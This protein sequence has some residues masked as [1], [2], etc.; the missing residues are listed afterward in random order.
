VGYFDHPAIIGAIEELGRTNPNVVVVS[1]DNGAGDWFEGGFPAEHFDMGISEENL[2]GVGAGL[3]HVGKLVI[4]LAMAPFVS[5]RGFEQIRDDC[6]Y[7]RNNVKII[8]MF[9]GLEAGPWGVTHHGIE[10]IALMRVIP[11]MTIIVPAD[12][13]DVHRAICAAGK[14]DGPVYLRIPGWAA[15]MAPLEGNDGDFTIGRAT[16]LREGT[17]LTLIATG[18]MVRTALA[19]HDALAADKICTRVLNM[20]TIKPIDHEA[21]V[22]A[23][24]ETETLLTLEEHTVIG[25]LGGAVAEIVAEIGSGRVVRLGIPDRFVTEIGPYPELLKLCGLDAASVESEVRKWVISS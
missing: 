10:D 15:E 25:G 24:Q 18:T 8:A 2:V 22:R 9:T 13:R 20:H 23:A 4:V 14:T 21:V 12:D 11:G 6:A 1:Q 19:V 5:M 7:N 16:T 3:A 17:D